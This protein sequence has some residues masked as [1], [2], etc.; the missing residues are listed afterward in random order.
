VV[1]SLPAACSAVAGEVQTFLA[2]N[3]VTPWIGGGSVDSMFFPVI[4]Q[5]DYEAFLSVMHGE[6]PPAYEEW[7]RR[8][9]DRVAYWNK[10]H[11]IVEVKVQA[12]DFAAYIRKRGRG[13]DMKS[14][15]D[16]TAFVGERSEG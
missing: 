6:L 15:F 4:V 10:T 13:A 14:L 16:F 11:R 3:A 1:F 8:H 7:L 2:W 5:D 12:D 9:A